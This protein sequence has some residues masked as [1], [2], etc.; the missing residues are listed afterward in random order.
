[1][2]IRMR[3][4]LVLDSSSHGSSSCTSLVVSLSMKSGVNRYLTFTFSKKL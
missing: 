4:T 3:L 2:I 1:M